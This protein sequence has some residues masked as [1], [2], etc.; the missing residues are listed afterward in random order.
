M[1]VEI[2]QLKDHS[3]IAKTVS[4]LRSELAAANK[5]VGHTSLF[6]F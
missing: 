1:Q 3:E 5:K 2:K 6:I 4:E